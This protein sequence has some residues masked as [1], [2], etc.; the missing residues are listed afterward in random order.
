MLTIVGTVPVK[1]M[2]L[3]SGPCQFRN[4]KLHVYDSELPLINGTS[5]MLAAAVTTSASLGIENPYVILAG[6]IGSGDGSNLIYRFLR[7]RP[8]SAHN[9]PELEVFA[10]H[11][12]KPNILYAKEAVKG[13][14]RNPNAILIADAGAMYVA[15]AAGIAK[16][17]DLFT[18]DPGEMAFLADPDAVHPAYARN[19]LFESITDMPSLI[20]QAYENSNASKFLLVKGETDYIVDKGKI[21]AK[22]AKP[23]VAA[24]EPI[25]GTGDSIAGIVSSLIASGLDVGHAAVLAAKAN[26]L[27]GEF[28]NP[29]PST[30]VWEMLSNIPEALKEAKTTQAELNYLPFSKN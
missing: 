27:M 15:K 4:G 21:V 13:L 20:K 18:P 7:D 30:K 6:D 17:F 14:K 5:V 1:G 11:Y 16:E 26:R 12:I 24:L 8:S 22:V 10:L 23:C 3:T 19:Y 29:N 28:S 2:P 25:G 9:P